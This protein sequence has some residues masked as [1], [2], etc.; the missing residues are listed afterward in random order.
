M[1]TA[2]KYRKT[3]NEHIEEIEARAKAEGIELDYAK[4]SKDNS[5]E[6]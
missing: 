6:S 4:E 1:R 3:T 5:D 2:R